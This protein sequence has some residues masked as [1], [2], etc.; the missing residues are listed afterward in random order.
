M[1]AVNYLPLS[2]VSKVVPFVQWASPQTT[3]TLLATA[4]NTAFGATAGFIQVVADTT[5]GLTTNALVI[6]NDSTV[7]TVPA[8]N[9]IS[10]VQGAWIQITPAQL[11]AGYTQYFTS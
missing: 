1:A 3:V 2:E 4:L 6:A 10:Y 8:S 7:M 9:W 5:S 11:T